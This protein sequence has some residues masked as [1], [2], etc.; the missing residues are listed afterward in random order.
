MFIMGKA[1]KG[2]MFGR[3]I[4]MDLGTSTCLVYVKGRGVI[5]QEPSV[6]AVDKH[7]GKVITVGQEA[8]R[9]L[10]HTPGD[11]VAIRPL[12]AGLISDYAMTERIL[13]EALCKTSGSRVFKPRLV[14]SVPVSITEVE[15]RALIDA[16]LQAGA[17]RVYLLEE[18][19]AAALGAGIDIT[20]AD[21]NMVLDI[22]AG[23][24]DI[25]VLS[26]S[27]IVESTSLKAAGDQFDEAIVKYIRRKHNVLIGERIAEELKRRIGC[28]VP[29]LL[30]VSTEVKGRSLTTGLPETFTITSTDMVQAVQPVTSQILESIQTI[31]ER[32]PPE[33]VL[34]IEKNGILLTGGGSLLWGFDQLIT[35][36]TG[37]KTR[38]LDDPITVVA[39]GT[40]K[41]LEHLGDL[42]EG[43]KSASFPKAMKQ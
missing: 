34:D 13:R 5:L 4:G 40:G 27:S 15:E 30:E 36:H 42:Q 24:T 2:S 22:G 33:L 38:V 23:S 35:K 41:T 9:M 29:R 1:A 12:R 26:L 6:V 39:L 8:E 21:G 7:T 25:A 28:V 37:I 17:R 11:L 3:D 19:L 10:S 31:L 32:T 18:P 43:T 20:K 14:I 16:G